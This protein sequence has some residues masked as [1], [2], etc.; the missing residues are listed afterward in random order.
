[1]AFLADEFEARGRVEVAIIQTPG[2]TIVLA[3]N[4]H[5]PNRPTVLIYGHYDVQPVDPIELW[6]HPPFEPHVENGVV[7]ARGASDNKGQ[8]WSH[9]LGVTEALR[10]KGDLPVNLIFLIEG[11]GEEGQA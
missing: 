1:M 2:H 4:K 6:T 9:I 5:Q 8:I 3:K 7:T 10:E 11:G